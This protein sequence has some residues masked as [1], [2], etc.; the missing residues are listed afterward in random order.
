MEADRACEGCVV[1][2]LGLAIA[3]DFVHLVDPGPREAEA[4]LDVTAIQ[5]AL[6]GTEDELAA[7]VGSNRK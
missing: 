1:S 3:G 5:A 4:G 2:K 6:D 7:A